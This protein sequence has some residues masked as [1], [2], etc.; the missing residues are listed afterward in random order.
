MSTKQRILEAALTLFNDQG[1][2]AVTTN[3]IA[4]HLNISPGNLYYHFKNKQAIIFELFLAYETRVLEYLSVPDDRP[5]TAADK[6]NY[7]KDVFTGL[8]QYRFMHRDMEHLLNADDALHARYR[9]FF[10]LCLEQVR[11]IYRGLRAVGMIEL[12]DDDVDALA[13]NT[14]IVVTS[15]FSFLRCNLMEEN[16][17]DITLE[18]LW[19]GIYQI[20]ALERPFLTDDYRAEILRLQQQLSPKPDWL[21]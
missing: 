20:F 8:W 21:S 1:E 19:G 4:A 16:Q 5:L 6:V 13:L 17:Q 12:N 11:K 3:H 14:W 2:R 10:Q 15:W 7:L 9:E 18:M